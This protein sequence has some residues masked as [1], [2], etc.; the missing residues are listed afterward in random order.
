MS[1]YRKR[2]LAAPVI[3]GAITLAAAGT[4]VALDITGTDGPDRII[5][6]RGADTIHALG[7]PRPRVR[8]RR[9]RRRRARR[10]R[11]LRPR[12]RRRRHARPR[13]GQRPRRTPDSATTTSP[14][15]S[16]TTASSPAG[17]T[18]PST[19]GP[20]STACAGA[21]AT[22]RSPAA[23][24]STSCTAAAAP[25]RCRAAPGNDRLFSGWRGDGAH[26]TPLNGDEGDDRILVRDGARDVVTCGPGSTACGPIRPDSVAADCETVSVR[27]A[28]SAGM[29]SPCTSD[30]ARYSSSSSS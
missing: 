29:R 7:R 6:S 18:T 25:T 2:L 10:R 24:A 13:R 23:R 8:A 26:A 28:V 16:A 14:A 15:A 27:T 21:A 22:T 11:R 5:G 1:H 9:R 17:A 30:W 12:R 20:G 3:A 4:A 19:P